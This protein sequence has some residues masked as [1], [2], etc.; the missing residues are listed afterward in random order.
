MSALVVAIEGI[1]GSGKGTQAARAREAICQR[2]ATCGLIAFPRYQ[3]T[4]FGRAI[5]KYLNGEFGDLAS[6]G[7]HFAALLYAG[8]RFESL[9]LIESE[10]ARCQVLL[11]DRYV[12]SNLAHQAAKLPPAEREPFIDWIESIEFDTYE[13]PRPDFTILLDLPVTIAQRLIAQKPARSYTT[14]SADLHEADA[15]YL[16]QTAEVYRRLTK[17]GGAWRVISCVAGDKLR[18]ASD[19]HAE[20]MR[21]IDTE[22]ATVAG[23]RPCP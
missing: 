19:I 4:A 1:D 9:P 23:T 18:S 5:A 20:I 10:A 7:A 12:A 3:S 22:R 6:A 8:D 14:K 13:L 21:L 15:N 11:F 17:R 16:E 2:G